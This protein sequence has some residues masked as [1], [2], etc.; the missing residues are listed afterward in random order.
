MTFYLLLSAPAII[1]ADQGQSNSFVI[2]GVRVFDGRKVLEQNDVWVEGGKI[3]AV[4]KNLKVP[5]SVKTVE[6]AGDT[7]LPA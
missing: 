5:S 7:L 1:L 6:A 2:R 4:G 3:K